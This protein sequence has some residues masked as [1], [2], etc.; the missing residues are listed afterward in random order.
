MSNNL[1][2]KRKFDSIA[3]NYDSIS[4]PYTVKRR[5]DALKVDY[6]KLI[7]D[8]GSGSG[9]VT[10]SHDSKIISSDFSFEMCKESKKRHDFV[11]CCDAEFLPFKEDIFDA[12]ISAEMIYYL[13][14]PQNFIAYSKKIL[15]DNGTLLFTFPNEDMTI[16]DSVRAILRRIGFSKMYFDDGVRSFTKIDHL[17]SMLNDN[18]FKITSIDKQVLF[19]FSSLDSINKTLEKTPLNHF[20]IF[21]VVRAEAQKNK[22][23]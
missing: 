21:I 20:S 4:N 17:K 7:L 23:C 15:K 22:S 6:A 9:L 3:K 12:V 14:Q 11:V 8:V 10:E 13:E 18:D 1:E 5:S 16:I 2:F 19:P